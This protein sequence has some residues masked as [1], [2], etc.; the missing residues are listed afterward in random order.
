M[1]KTTGFKLVN[2]AQVFG[3]LLKL[4]PSVNTATTSTCE[5]PCGGSSR[6]ADQIT[7]ARRYDQYYLVH[8]TG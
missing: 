6:P 5:V 4:A 2:I 8:A 7:I 1:T 3:K